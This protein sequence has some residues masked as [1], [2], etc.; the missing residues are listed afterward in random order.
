MALATT[1]TGPELKAANLKRH[2]DSLRYDRFSEA[3]RL[4]LELRIRRFAED[5]ESRGYHARLNIVTSLYEGNGGKT[6]M[7]TVTVSRLGDH[8]WPLAKPSRASTTERG[9]T[10]LL[11]SIEEWIR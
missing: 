7:L 4:N 6:T 2:L 10:D 8:G 9:V 11:N 5:M 1:L 3:I